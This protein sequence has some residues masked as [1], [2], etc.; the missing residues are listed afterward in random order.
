MKVRIN[1]RIK[2][3]QSIWWDDGVCMI[4]QRGIPERV[5]IFRAEDLN[6]L[7][8]SVRDMVIRGAP[9]IG[10]AAAYGMAL[11]WKNH[12]DM[13][14]AARTIKGTRPTARDLY[15]AVELMLGAWREGRDVIADAKR[16]A[17][18]IVEMCRKIGEHGVTLLRKGVRVLTHCNAGALATVD[19]GTALAPLRVAER[20]GLDPFVYVD[21]TRPRLQG[22]RLTA[23][24][25]DNEGIA[26][27]II[28]DNAAGY[29]M[30]RGDVDIVIVGADR[31]ASNGDI[32]NKIGTYEKAVL[33][34]ENGIPF[35]VAAPVSTFDPG[36]MSGR[37]IPIE[38]R[39]ENEVL[40]IDGRYISPKGSHAFNPAFDITPAKYI[41][42][43]ITEYGVFKREMIPEMIE[44][45]KTGG[46]GGPRDF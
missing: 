29:Y 7:A 39:D 26:Y 40:M 3:M 23:W 8:F 38:E 19:Y 34:K 36:I 2:E 11:A 41:T 18:G 12:E 33:A 14:K 15:Y 43:Y 27:R 46:S 44:R 1:G 17:D 24:E 35:Y 21:E 4:D 32:A 28:C 16:Y 20:R 9:A 30:A 13:D 6:A 42:G 22:A 25:L 10:V 5:E 31:V 45:W 37:E